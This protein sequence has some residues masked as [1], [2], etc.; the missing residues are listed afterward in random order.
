MSSRVPSDLPITEAGPADVPAVAEF[1]WSAW[2][3]AGPDAPGWA[4]A[5]EEVVRDLAGPEA[6]LARIGGPDRRMFLAWEGSRVVGFAAIRRLSDD[7]VELAG[8]VVLQSRVGSGIGTPLLEAARASA[9]HH[10]HRRMVARTEADNERAIRF[11]TS[12]G[13]RRTGSV[14]EEIEGT[15]VD[16]VEL[17]L[18]LATA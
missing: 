10:G 6:L 18:D 8:I 11:Y 5:S 7:A 15:P 17:D 2:R 1:F 12:R 14:T 4:G 16:L 3:E 9:V 13:F